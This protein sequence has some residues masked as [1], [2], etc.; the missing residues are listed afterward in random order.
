MFTSTSENA[1]DV[2]RLVE[3]LRAVSIG[4]TIS[5]AQLD[6][7]IGRS[8]QKRR[9]LLMRAMDRLSAETGAVFESVFG[10]GYRRSPVE[11]IP[12]VG[13][14]ARGRIRRIAKRGAKRLSN[15]AARAND[16]PSP[17]ALEINR[18]LAVLGMIQSMSR[19]NTAKKATVDT[20][21]TS[22]APLAVV[23]QR[24]IEA[25]R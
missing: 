12:A 16:M 4:E 23:A 19:D 14:R 21:D 10:V 7:A 20:T 25:L 17:I 11:H 9:Y 3:R 15:A 22:P 2:S 5:F 13:V 8:V 6:T 24:L 1:A 18:E